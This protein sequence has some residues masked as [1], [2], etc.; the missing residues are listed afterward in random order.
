[1]TEKD[2]EMPTKS[3]ILLYQTGDGRPRIE[4]RLENETVLLNQRLMS[5]LFQKDVRTINE[6]I[7]NIYDEGELTPEATIWKFRIVQTEGCRQVSRTVD[8]Y[9][10]DVII[11]VGYR[12]HSHRGTQFRQW[13]TERLR[14]F[15]VKGFTLDDEQGERL[16]E[17]DGIKY[18]DELL[19]ITLV[20]E[21]VRYHLEISRG[22]IEII[23]QLFAP[24]SIGKTQ[25]D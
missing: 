9:N 8:F 22:L 13:A 1:M 3:S 2:S 10:L 4:V 15:I 21:M 19:A 7:K 14:E 11:A 6:H 23:M 25:S 16:S 20:H 17:S 24:D 12:V 18:I 5:E